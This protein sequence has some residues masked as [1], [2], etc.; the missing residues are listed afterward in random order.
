MMLH[1][2]L[3]DKVYILYIEIDKLHRRLLSNLLKIIAK[4]SRKTLKTNYSKYLTSK[5]DAN[6]REVSRQYQINH[7]RDHSNP[8]SSHLQSYDFSKCGLLS[9]AKVIKIFVI[10]LSNLNT[11]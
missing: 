3:V 10:L 9:N 5:V 8:Q 2:L 4:E 11:I 6:T 7:V 1:I